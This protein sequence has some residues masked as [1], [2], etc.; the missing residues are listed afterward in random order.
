MEKRFVYSCP[1]CGSTEVQLRYPVWVDA[2]NIDDK[3]KWELDF[4]AS[5]E[6]DSDSGYCME[7]GNTELLKKEV[8]DEPELIGGPVKAETRF[9]CKHCSKENCLEHCQETEDGKHEA[10]PQSA[11]VPAGSEFLVD[12]TCKHCGQS[13]SLAVDEKDI[14]WE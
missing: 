12:Y 9:V 4:E 8:V 10:D 3:E 2:N 6:K 5:P 14:M 13:G 7:C 11:T 1:N